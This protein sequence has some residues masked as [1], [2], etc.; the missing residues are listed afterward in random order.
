MH[1]SHLIYTWDL[2]STSVIERN[3]K[4]AHTNQWLMVKS[5]VFFLLLKIKWEKC[6]QNDSG[7]DIII[8]KHHKAEKYSNIHLK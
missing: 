5:W 3:C 4:Y 7:I 1:E 8:Q 2:K 6:T